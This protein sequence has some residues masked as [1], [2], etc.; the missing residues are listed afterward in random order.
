MSSTNCFLPR[1]G[2]CL[3]LR[4]RAVKSLMALGEAARL[5]SGGL[6]LGLLGPKR[7]E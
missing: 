6:R 5:R 7:L 3:N 4:V 1:R 2:F